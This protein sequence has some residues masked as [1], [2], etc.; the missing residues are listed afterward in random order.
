MSKHSYETQ[1]YHQVGQL[2]HGR[3]VRFRF[4]LERH[5]LEC[6]PLYMT[7]HVDVT[8]TKL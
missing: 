8:M 3:R 2:T 7:S 4:A 6:Y 1:T 5:S